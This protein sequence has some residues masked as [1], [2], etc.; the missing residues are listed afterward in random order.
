MLLAEEVD[1]CW[2]HSHRSQLGSQFHSKDLDFESRQDTKLAMNAVELLVMN[3]SNQMDLPS[4]KREAEEHTL[5]LG[6]KGR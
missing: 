1:S 3:E 2:W 6:P 5:F 4:K